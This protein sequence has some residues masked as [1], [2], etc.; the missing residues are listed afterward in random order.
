MARLK[1]RRQ[2]AE[3]RARFRLRSESE[4][5]VETGPRTVD[6]P[7]IASD[8]RPPITADSL[9]E[10]KKSTVSKQLVICG[11]A[12]NITDGAKHNTPVSR[13]DHLTACLLSA[14]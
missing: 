12:V 2:A 3:Q 8:A 14:L 10:E 11:F 13:S 6:R 4:T 5:F 1:R 7:G 9:C